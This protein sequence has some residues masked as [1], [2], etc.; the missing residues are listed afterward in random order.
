MNKPSKKREVGEILNK[1]VLSI[2][3]QVTRDYEEKNGIWEGMS[4]SNQKSL[5][6]ARKELT[7]SLSDAYRA[8]RDAKMDF[9]MIILDNKDQKLR[10]ADILTEPL[11]PLDHEQSK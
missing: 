7:Q 2:G 11:N 8:G 1:L 6:K 5:E 4:Y 9:D 3:H 10:Q